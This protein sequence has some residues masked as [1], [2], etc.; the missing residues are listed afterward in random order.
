[1]PDAHDRPEYQSDLFRRGLEVRKA[2]LGADY[3]EASLASADDF[4]AAFQQIT[5]EVAWGSIW[6]RPG[7]P[8]KTRSIVVL[9]MLAALSKPHELKLHVRGALT[10]GVSRDEI[11]EVLLHACGYA[12][13]PAGL[14]AFRAAAEVFREIDAAAAPPV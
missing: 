11:K 4:F 8:R 2:V 14:E 10:N 9:A 12:G 5:T 7:L 13:I 6:T 3:V 1:M